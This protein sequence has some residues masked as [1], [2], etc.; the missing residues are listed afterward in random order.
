M[1]FFSSW[2]LYICSLS[3]TESSQAFRLPQARAPVAGLEP[4]A[5]E[6]SLHIVERIRY[7]LRYERLESEEGHDL[8]KLDNAIY[9][10][11]PC[12]GHIVSGTSR[13]FPPWPS[14]VISSCNTSVIPWLFI[15]LGLHLLLFPG[16]L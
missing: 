16:G 14:S 7:S 10:H 4:L 6:S 11:V 5:R 12:R 15:R 2:F 3:T 1:R 13:S 9:P 8:Y